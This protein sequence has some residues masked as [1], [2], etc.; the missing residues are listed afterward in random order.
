MLRVTVFQFTIGLFCIILVF[1][2]VCN[3]IAGYLKR[4]AALRQNPKPPRD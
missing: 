1:F 3:W 2:Y 4:L